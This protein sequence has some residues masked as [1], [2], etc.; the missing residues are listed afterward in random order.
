[1]YN[2]G[3]SLA[4]NY[5]IPTTTSYQVEFGTQNDSNSHDFARQ[6]SDDFHC[7]FFLGV[8]PIIYTTSS[9]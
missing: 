4:V 8:P 1:M 5:T 9:G 2:A 7:G 6:A 3:S